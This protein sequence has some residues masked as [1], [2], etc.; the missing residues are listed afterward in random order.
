MGRN[1]PFLTSNNI[2]LW[3][4][5]VQFKKNAIDLLS[6]EPEKN[7]L[8]SKTDLELFLSDSPEETFIKFAL[9]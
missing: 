9:L 6:S 7:A 3:V 4:C 5:E 8:L 2:I 1:T